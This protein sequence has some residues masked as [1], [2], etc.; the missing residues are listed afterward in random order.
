M[1][2]QAVVTIRDK[3]WQVAIADTPWELEQGLGNIPE[4]LTGTGMLF[5]TGWEQTIAVTTV[6]MLFPI[7]VAFMSESLVITEVY[8]NVQPGYLITSTLPARYFL[9]VNAGEFEGIG[10]GDRALA[11]LLPLEEVIMPDWVSTMIGFMGFI[12]MGAFVVSVARDF[13]RVMF[14]E[15]K[16]RPGLHGPR[17]EKLLPQ[18]KRNEYVWLRIGDVAEYE[19]FDSPY[20]AGQAVGNRLALRPHEHRVLSY[21]YRSAGVE[22]EPY[23]TGRNYISLFRGDEEAQWLKDLTNREKRDFERGVRS[24]LGFLPKVKASL[25]ARAVELLPA[26][27]GAGQSQPTRDDVSVNSWV[28]RDRLGIWI[29][30]NR[31]DKTIAEWWDDN[32]RRMFEQG[33]FKPGDV[34]HQEITGRAFEESVL[35]YAESVGILAKENPGHPG[36]K[37]EP[38]PEAPQSIVT[39]WAGKRKNIL[40]LKKDIEGIRET[41]SLDDVDDAI[42]EYEDI[43][44]ED[45]ETGEEYQEEKDAAWENIMDAIDNAEEL[46]TEDSTDDFDFAQFPQSLPRTV[47]ENGDIGLPLP[48]AGAGRDRLWW[49]ATISGRT[50]TIEVTGIGSLSQ[51]Q[52]EDSFTNSV[53]RVTNPKKLTLPFASAGKGKLWWLVTTQDNKVTEVEVSGIRG[54]SELQLEGAF[55]NSTAGITGAAPGVGK[56]TGTCYANAWRF[57]IREGEGELIHGTVFSGGRRMGH[58]WVV[59]SSDWVWEPETGRYFTRLGF[60]DAFAPAIESRYTAEEAAIMAARTKNLGPWSEQERRRYLKGKSPAVIPKHGRQPRL[61]GEIEFLPDSPEFLA[62]TIDDIGYRDKIDNAFLRAIARARGE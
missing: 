21:H 47:H 45:Y 26:V 62:Y 60:S 20:E 41:Y 7:D 12:V 15:P 24:E 51:R 38:T 61:K 37:P 46:E 49:L 29:T 3:Q 55:A 39:K 52:L 25:P 18:T 4:L 50:V 17:G 57:L 59:T 11:E 22:I 1:A 16:E 8:R 33:F 34:R 30:D 32:A 53:A 23:Y 36:A 42:A 13:T 28:E 31:T 56:P 54:L 2:G 14:E 43:S 19:K 6:P 5:D 9:E 40:L 44:R 27:K 35:D 48:F 58:A 10:S